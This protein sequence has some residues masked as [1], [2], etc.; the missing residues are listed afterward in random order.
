MGR[1]L[2]TSDLHFGHPKVAKLRGFTKLDDLNVIGTPDGEPEVI[3]DTEAHDEAIIAGWNKAVH[4]DDL[5]FILGDFAMNWKGAEEKLARLRGRKVLV[6]GNHDIFFGAGRGWRHMGEWI[7]KDKFEAIIPLLQ[8]NLN[9]RAVLL[10]HF[11]YEGDHV[12]DRDRHTQFRPRDEG[13]WLLHGHI[14]AKTK[15]GA[16]RMIWGPPTGE[17]DYR[18]MHRGRQIHIGVDAWDLRPVTEDE[19][20]E[21]MREEEKRYLLSDEDR[22]MLRETLD[23]IRRA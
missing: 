1:R 23:A 9:G 10:S 12:G 13:K 6:T 15:L 7:G 18:P 21:I 8:V 19:V 14:H 4:K 3:G 5:T 20:L 22:T 16:P 17:P 2:F 11:P